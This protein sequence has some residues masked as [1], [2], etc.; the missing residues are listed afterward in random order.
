MIVD[1]GT[2]NTRAGV[3]LA[4]GDCISVSTVE[5]SY[6]ND[7]LYP[8]ATTFSPTEMWENVLKVSKDV[9]SRAK[10]VKIKAIT[11]TSGRQG[12]VLID[13]QMTPYLGLPNIDNR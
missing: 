10:D 8:D 13:N 5:T 1:I 12:I 2:G 11:A 6:Y 7:D 4:N 9:L 3:A